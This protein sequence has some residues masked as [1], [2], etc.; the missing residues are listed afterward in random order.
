MKFSTL[1][2]KRQQKLRN[3]M[4]VDVDG[5]DNIVD[6]NTRKIVPDETLYNFFEYSNV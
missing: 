1:S 3:T 2:E 4:Q 5:N 6:H